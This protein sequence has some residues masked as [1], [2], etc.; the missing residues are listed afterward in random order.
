MVSTLV[1]PSFSYS[2]SNEASIMGGMFFGFGASEPT[3]ETPLPSEY[4]AAGTTAF[5]SVSFFF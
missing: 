1:S 2:L 4:G 5:V 3:E